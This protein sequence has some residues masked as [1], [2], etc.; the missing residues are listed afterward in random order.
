[1]GSALARVGEFLRACSLW[2][3]LLWLWVGY[4]VLGFF[5]GYPGTA[6][7]FPN[8]TSLAVGWLLP[9]VVALTDLGAIAW[10]YGL[11]LAIVLAV[12]VFTEFPQRWLWVAIA[13]GL[14]LV[15]VPM[16][17]M[18]L[19]SRL[20]GRL[21]SWAGY[22]AWVRSLAVLLELLLC[23]LGLAAGWVVRWLRG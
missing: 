20:Q 14:G 16:V 11:S 17:L 12:M 3:W 10:G 9:A 2:F 13:L 22:G 19:E 21:P 23:G 8:L 6:P 7:S 15:A 5:L 1:M 18:G 4:G